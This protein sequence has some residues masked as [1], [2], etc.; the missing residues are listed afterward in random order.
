MSLLTHLP[1]VGGTDDWLTDPTI[2]HTLG[3]FTLDPA[4]P[5]TMPWRT[6]KTMWT[7]RDGPLEREWFDLVWLNPPFSNWHTWT[8][9]LAEHGDGI[10]LLPARTDT[11]GFFEHVWSNPSA[12]CFVRGRVSFYTLG[13]IR[14]RDN[15]G[16]AICLVAFGKDAKRRLESCKFGRTVT[17]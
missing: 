16:F 2:I 1:Q 9:K 4:C 11:R 12:V 15:C 17:L 14:S 5:D 8:E 13:G 3:P 10:V 7:R 6:A